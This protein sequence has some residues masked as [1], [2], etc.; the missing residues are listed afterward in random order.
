MKEV[1]LSSEQI[2]E[3]CKR[4][5]EEINE[6]LKNE[7]RIPVLVG[8]MKGSLNF[9]MDLIKYIKV[10]F[11]TDYIQISSYFGTTR[12]N[13]V[14]LLKDLSYDCSNRTVIIVEDIVDTGHSMNFLIDHI[15]RH[16][17]KKVLVCTLIDKVVARE[18][19]VQIDFTGY[20]LNKNRFL[21]GFGLD[22]NELERNLPYIYEADDDD[23]ARLDGVISKD[24]NV[25]I[26]R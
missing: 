18:V 6:A 7:E 2:E 21:I 24:G 22:Y 8:V 9:M 14:R 4:V 1:L 3:I 15:K 20:V 25:P 5:G 11:Y 10:P 16:D 13:A 26:N 19:P 23:V 12:T 17:A